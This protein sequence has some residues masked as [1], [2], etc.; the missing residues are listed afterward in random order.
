MAMTDTP[1]ICNEPGWVG[2]FTRHQAA[3]AIANGTDIV[4]AN[5]EAGDANKD[6]TRGRV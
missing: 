5:S 3:G 1:Q 2:A 6:G 4:K